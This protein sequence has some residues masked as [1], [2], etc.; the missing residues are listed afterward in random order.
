M[1]R[2]DVE[3]F[4]GEGVLFYRKLLE[5]AVAL[6][7]LG[8]MDSCFLPDAHVNGVI[9]VQRDQRVVV[10]VQDARDTDDAVLVD[11][12]IAKV[13]LQ[14]LDVL[15]Q[16]LHQVHGAVLLDFVPVQVQIPEGQVLFQCVT[17]RLPPVHFNVVTL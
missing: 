4:A 11:I 2:D 17:Q 14:Q 16:D 1:L 8:E 3:S 6:Q 15:E 7:H 10:P 5:R 13:Q 12:I 9:Q